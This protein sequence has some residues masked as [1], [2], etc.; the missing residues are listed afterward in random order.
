MLYNVEQFNEI[1]TKYIVQEFKEF[2]E[3]SISLHCKVKEPTNH[4]AVLQKKIEQISKNAGD[5]N[6]IEMSFNHSIH[7]T[8]YD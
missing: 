5:C 4:V 1:I 2:D 6:E 8:I 7:D 3:E